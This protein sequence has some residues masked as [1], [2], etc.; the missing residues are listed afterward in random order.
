VQKNVLEEFSGFALNCEE[1]IFGGIE[2]SDFLVF[3][4]G[5]HVAPLRWGVTICAF[6]VNW[7]KFNCV[8]AAGVT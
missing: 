2:F 7:S 3:W 5:S 6:C 1:N 4:S 8:G